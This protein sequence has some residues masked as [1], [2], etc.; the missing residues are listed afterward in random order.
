MR[1]GI[2]LDAAGHPHAVYAEPVAGASGTT[3]ILHVWHD[4]AAW[5][6]EEIARR[7]FQ[8][9]AR[10]E[11]GPGGTLYASWGAGAALELATRA[12]GAW[13]IED[14]AAGVAS[15]LHPLFGFGFHYLSGDT[16]GFP[17]VVV[18][19]NAHYYHLLRDASGWAL[20]N[21]GASLSIDGDEDLQFA[22][23]AGRAVI[24]L[25]SFGAVRMLQ[26][27]AAGWDGGSDF[28]L[29]ASHFPSEIAF[30]MARSA[31]GQSL[32]LALG[33]INSTDAGKVWVLGGAGWTQVGTWYAVN[34]TVSLGFRS[35]GKLWLVSG[36]QDIAA[37]SRPAPVALYE[38]L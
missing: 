15:S 22:C 8:P 10:V 1:P 36:L 35:D 19:D 11:I 34:P 7:A 4:G 24:A 37:S 29:G 6:R 18:V 28:S 27:T 31:D 25:R 38:Q 9:R 5:Q 14:L 17:H 2:V 30:G 12:N 26:R 3:A 32:A 16:D 13:T 21:V 23:G 33:A 20:E